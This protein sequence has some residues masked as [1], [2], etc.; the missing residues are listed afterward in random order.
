MNS[1]NVL[2]WSQHG[3]ITN[4]LLILADPRLLCIHDALH[5]LLAAPTAHPKDTKPEDGGLGLWRLAGAPERLGHPGHMWRHA[6][7]RAL[8]HAAPNAPPPASSLV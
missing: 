4:M 7:H 8:G 6:C 1:A 2:R 3:R 5:H